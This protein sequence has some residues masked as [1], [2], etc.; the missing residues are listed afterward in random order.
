MFE[1]AATKTF[2]STQILGL[3][4]QCI[5]MFVSKF[6]ATPIL[7]Y[8]LIYARLYVVISLQFFFLLKFFTDSVLR[9]KLVEL[10]LYFLLLS[11]KLL[12]A[13]LKPLRLSLVIALIMNRRI[14]S[15]IHTNSLFDR[16]LYS[17]GPSASLLTCTLCYL[18]YCGE[19]GSTL[20]QA[21]HLVEIM[22]ALHLLF[23]LGYLLHS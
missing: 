11:L 20:S 22:S 19:I 12:E 21:F 9:K 15:W 18:E 6:F 23:L 10:I 2:N 17:V 8:H 13:L 4:G 16:A 5:L 1:G 3:H 7:L 14:L